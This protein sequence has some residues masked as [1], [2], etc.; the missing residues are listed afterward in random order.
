MFAF[1]SN[2]LAWFVI[3]FLA[4]SFAAEEPKLTKEECTCDRMRQPPSN[5]PK[6]RV[7]GGQIVR[8]DGS[9]DDLASTAVIYLTY[10]KECSPSIKGSIEIDSK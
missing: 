5:N 10:D 3:A 4:Y 8:H 6:G 9:V 1:Q 7:I 2:R